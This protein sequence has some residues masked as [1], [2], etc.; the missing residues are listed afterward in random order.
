MLTYAI[1]CAVC[2]QC[3]PVFC[4]F[5]SHLL[6]ACTLWRVIGSDFKA[7]FQLEHLYSQPNFYLIFG[8]I[9]YVY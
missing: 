3:A 2:N 6:G 9:Q 5:F 1:L 8:D 4:V 7:T